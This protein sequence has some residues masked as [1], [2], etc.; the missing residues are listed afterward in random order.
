MTKKTCS[1]S[2][3]VFFNHN[4]NLKKATCLNASRYDPEYV[5]AFE[6]SEFS[7][8]PEATAFQHNHVFRD[9]YLADFY[10]NGHSDFIDNNN[11]H[12]GNEKEASEWKRG[13][14]LY[15]RDKR[16]FE[17]LPD[18]FRDRF[19]NNMFK[20]LAYLDNPINREEMRNLDLKFTFNTNE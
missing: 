18:A 2:S 15:L 9:N 4:S 8:S 11:P 20:Y 13:H 6:A 16:E 12:N 7:N 10:M 14:K 3:K 5:K 1:D 17:A 19:D